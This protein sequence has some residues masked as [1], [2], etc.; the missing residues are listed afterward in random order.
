[1]SRAAAVEAC[2]DGMIVM[3]AMVELA[4]TMLDLFRRQ[5]HAKLRR[6]RRLQGYLGLAGLLACLL[7]VSAVQGLCNLRV[8]EW[9]WQWRWAADRLD[10]LLCFLLLLRVCILWQ[11]TERGNREALSLELPGS[12][13]HASDLEDELGG[14]AL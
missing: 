4:V 11:P 1:M 7:V 5:Q 13:D 2:V 12:E 9:P 10:H 14:D 8:L 3:W 6:Y